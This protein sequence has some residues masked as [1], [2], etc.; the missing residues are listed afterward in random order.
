MWSSPTAP[1]PRYDTRVADI[2]RQSRT[3]LLVAAGFIAAAAITAVLPHESGAWLPL[4]LFLVGGLLT[5]ISTVTQL[6][7]VTWSSSPAPPVALA[8]GQLII[9]GVGAVALASGREFDVDVI[10][11]AGA[12][13]VLVA[14][15]LLCLILLWVRAAAGT[16]RFHPAIDG[17]ITAI[18]FSMVGVTLGIAAVLGGGKSWWPRVREAHLDANLFGLVGLIIAATL[19]YFVATQARMKMSPRATPQRLH[20]AILVLGA[21]VA[22]IEC[23]RGFNEDLVVAAGYSA[24]AL[25]LIWM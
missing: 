22:I 21:A 4:H 10:A 14:L 25:G 16:N 11:V 17:Y 7:A 1:H 6:L 8:K 2:H 13:M 9:L 5:V 20:I 19:P 23:G 3:G 15:A 24:Y 12:A 18:G